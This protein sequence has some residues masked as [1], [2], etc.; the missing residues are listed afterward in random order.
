[1]NKTGLLVLGLVAGFCSAALGIG[2]GVLMVP[3]LVLLFGCR[4]KTAVGT[5]LAA[6]VPTA[7]IAVITHYVVES[8]N[9]KWLAALFILVGSIAGAWFGAML[10]ERVRSAILKRL[11]AVL[12]LFVGLK[13]AGIITIP[14]GT[15]SSITFTPLLVLLGLAAGSSASLF[16]IGGGVIMV[17]MLNLFFGLTMHEAI[18]TSL[19][20]I[21]PTTI[22]GALFHH[23]LESIDA[24]A[25]RF[26]IPTALVGAV[27]GAVFANTM[28]AV[29]L[30]MTLGLLLLLSS[31]KLFLQRE[32]PIPRG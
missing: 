8:G 29:V 20:V 1:M 25:L 13:M 7:L 9:I 21:L 18:A 26:L 16:G 17:P 32:V 4:I 11:F 22:A 30:K 15:V 6:I 10:V 24:S 2:G 27:L 14:T 28:P 12:L 19:V 31:V 5:S 3:A 23:R